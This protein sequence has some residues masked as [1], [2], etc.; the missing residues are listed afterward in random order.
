MDMQVSYEYDVQSP[1]ESAGSVHRLRLKPGSHRKIAKDYRPKTGED[2][3]LLRE[4]V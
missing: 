1:I 4:S 2:H 3:K